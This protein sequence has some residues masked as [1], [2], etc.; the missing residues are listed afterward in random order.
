VLVAAYR[1]KPPGGGDSAAAVS[2]RRMIE[3]GIALG[4]PAIV[5]QEVLA[6][7][8][9]KTQFQELHRHLTAFLILP[10]TI[11]N[12]VKA[13]QL[14]AVSSEKR[15]HCTPSAALVVAQA[16]AGGCRLY[17]LDREMAAVARIGDVEL[18]GTRET[19]SEGR[20]RK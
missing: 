7:V 19:A 20:R 13:A 4:I 5:L 11:E 14:A 16:A 2:L 17:T 1:R 18:I 9:N 12:H 15:V 10:A 6:G 3:S 8:R